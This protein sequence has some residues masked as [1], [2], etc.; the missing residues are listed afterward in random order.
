MKNEIL[1]FTRK[2]R[3][4]L[5][6]ALRLGG[7]FSLNSQSINVNNEFSSSKNDLLI[8]NFQLLTFK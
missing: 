4:P 8:S 7:R 6:T 5:L 3:V 2:T 1:N